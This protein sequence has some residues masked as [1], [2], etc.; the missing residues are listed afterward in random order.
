[1]LT[2]AAGMVYEMGEQYCCVVVRVCGIYTICYTYIV[3]IDLSSLC[4]LISDKLVKF[5]L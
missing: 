4:S 3:S 5:K 2:N 1:M